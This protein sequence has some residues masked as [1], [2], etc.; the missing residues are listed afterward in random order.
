[1]TLQNSTEEVAE[2][3]LSASTILITFDPQTKMQRVLSSDNQTSG[4]LEATN[5]NRASHDS[6]TT[7]GNAEI[8]ALLLNYGL[9]CLKFNRFPT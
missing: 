6:E 1:M 4:E 9:V 7:S 5:D 3:L 8:N 2:T